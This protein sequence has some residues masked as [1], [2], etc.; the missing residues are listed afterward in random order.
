MEPLGKRDY[1]DR[2]RR[3]PNPLDIRAAICENC[4]CR[5]D[6]A[7]RIDKYSLLFEHT[8]LF[9]FDGNKSYLGTPKSKGYEV[10]RGGPRLAGAVAGAPRRGELAQRAAELGRAGACAPAEETISNLI[11]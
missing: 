11:L 3:S 5:F 8:F 4:I 6:D 7:S 10:A 1:F 2:P 9:Q